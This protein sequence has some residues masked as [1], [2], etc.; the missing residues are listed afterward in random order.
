M[1]LLAAFV[2]LL[3]RYTGDTDLIVG[4]PSSGRPPGGDDVV[5]YLVTML[6]LRVRF[7]ADPTGDDLLSAVREAS[8]DAFAHRDTPFLD[9]VRAVAPRRCPACTRC[10]VRLRGAPGAGHPPGG[11]HD[12]PVP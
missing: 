1:V 11:G 4:T 7:D 10:S 9:V 2:G 8:L 12:V 5:G 6:A 3:H